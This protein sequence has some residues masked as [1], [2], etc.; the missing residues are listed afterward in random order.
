[1]FSV[2]E[3]YVQILSF[4]FNLGWNV[5]LKVCITMEKYLK[6]YITL[7]AINYSFLLKKLSTNFKFKARKPAMNFWERNMPKSFSY[8]K[9]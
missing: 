9:F 1:M 2:P 5:S 7:H 8:F 3:N 4:F 6:Y